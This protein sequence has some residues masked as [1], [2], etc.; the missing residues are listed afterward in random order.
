MIIETKEKWNKTYK[1]PKK[2]RE[3]KNTKKKPIEKPYKTIKN[4]PR[5]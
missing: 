3:E 2:Y 5:I 1:K 4:R